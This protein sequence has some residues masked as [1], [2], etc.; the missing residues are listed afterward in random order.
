M[1]DYKAKRVKAIGYG[2]FLAVF[3]LPAGRSSRE[4][5]VRISLSVVLDLAAAWLRCPSAS[6]GHVLYH[7]VHPDRGPCSHDPHD[8]IEDR[9]EVAK[10]KK[11]FCKQR[12]RR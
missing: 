12:R 1:K 2:G 3:D 6:A 10:L 7:S 8:P 5:A 4:V 11:L 9:K